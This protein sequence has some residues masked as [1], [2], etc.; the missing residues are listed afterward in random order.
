M[1]MVAVMILEGAAQAVC[2]ISVSCKLSKGSKTAVYTK[3]AFSCFSTPVGP[4]RE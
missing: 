1:V 4:A 2:K 3:S